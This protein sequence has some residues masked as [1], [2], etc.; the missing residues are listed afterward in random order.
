MTVT[1]IFTFF[2]S[3]QVD[4]NHPSYTDKQLEDVLEHAFDHVDLNK[5]GYVDFIEYRVNHYKA[6]V[7]TEKMEK[8]KKQ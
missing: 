7:A 8:E 6:K 1:V 2:F 4:K 3:G 5:D